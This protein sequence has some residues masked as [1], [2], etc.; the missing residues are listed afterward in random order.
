MTQ[1]RM[2]VVCGCAVDPDLKTTDSFIQ[3]LDGTKVEIL[4]GNHCGA[5]QSESGGICLHLCER[6]YHFFSSSFSSSLMEQP[7]S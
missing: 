3:S 4:F 6:L 1:L 7:T 2:L 5:L